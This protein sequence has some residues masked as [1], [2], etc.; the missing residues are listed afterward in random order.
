MNGYDISYGMLVFF[1]TVSFL[2][3]I[4]GFASIGMRYRVREYEK[5]HGKFP[6]CCNRRECQNNNQS[7]QND[8]Q[9][10]QSTSLQ[11]QQQVFNSNDFVLIPMQ[12]IENNTQSIPQQQSM[13]F[14]PVNMQNQSIPMV[15]VAPQQ[16]MVPQSQFS[17]QQQQ[18][19]FVPIQQPMQFIPQQNLMQQQPQYVPFVPPQSNQNQQSNFVYRI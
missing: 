10:N 16:N 4:S 19:Q 18:M 3:G 1:M 9:N 17:P 2:V 15:F 12:N 7:S 13:Q 8:S 6:T 5:Y 11:P 14:N